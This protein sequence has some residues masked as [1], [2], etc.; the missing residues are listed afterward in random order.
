[1]ATVASVST[2]NPGNAS[3]I[4]VTK[5][6]G[7]AAGDLMIFHYSYNDA[8]DTASTISGWTH[9]VSNYGGTIK[10]GLQWKVADS[11]DVA[12]SDFTLGFTGT[13]GS[14]LGAVL[15]ITDYVVDGLL[16]ENKDTGANGDSTLAMGVTPLYTNNLLLFF[17]SNNEGLTTTTYSIATS[18][19]SWTE[20]YDIQ[21]GSITT[22]SCASATRTQTTAT[23]DASFTY[24]AGGSGNEDF[25]GILVA[26]ETPASVSTTLDAAGIVTLTTP[27]PS[28]VLGNII[29][30]DSAGTMTLST[31]EP[32]ISTS[33]KTAWTNETK[34]STTWTNE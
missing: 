2:A 8:T 20:Q 21:G 10:T 3:S 11:G 26:I 7:L 34:P 6:S 12:A 31:P 29:P 17:L 33:T 27:E 15:R 13:V 16:N 25:Y 28:F 23:G 19:P 32:T 1:M 14:P 30:V 5:P 4:T 18:N 22:L 24:G 9:E